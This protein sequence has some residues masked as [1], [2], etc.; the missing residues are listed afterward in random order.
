MSANNFADATAI[1]LVGGVYTSAPVDNTAHTTETNEP[2]TGYRSSWWSYTPGVNTHLRLDTLLSPSS[3]DTL[4][5]VYT[6]TTLTNLVLVDSN[7]ESGQSPLGPSLIPEVDVVAGTTYYIRVAAVS[8]SALTYILT[9]TEVAAQPYYFTPARINAQTPLVFL[10]NDRFE[11]A[12]IVLKDAAPWVSTVRDND[13]YTVQDDESFLGVR[14]AW[15]SY[16]PGSDGQ[17]EVFHNA[18]TPDDPDKLIGVYT[19]TALDDLVEVPDLVEGDPSW[20]FNAVAGTTYYIRL[21]YMTDTVTVPYELLV[22]G[23]AVETSRD[24]TIPITWIVDDAETP[25]AHLWFVE[26]AVGDVGDRVTA[27]GLGLGPTGADV[28]IAGVPATGITFS[29]VEPSAEAGGG[30]RHINAVTGTTNLEHDS[31]TFTVPDVS[32][33]GGPLYVEGF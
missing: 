16:T 5:E 27:V 31:I 20:S 23:P 28:Y 24:A 21:A 3:P 14:S 32:A 11:D 12:E 30:T 8:D 2:G 15:W 25:P 18:G 19:G 26:P 13:I 7:D 4:I 10:P 9:V 33:P 17:V 22:Y 6:G 1:T 29:A